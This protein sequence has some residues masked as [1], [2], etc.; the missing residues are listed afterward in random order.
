MRPTIILLIF[1]AVTLQP[2]ARIGAQIATDQSLFTEITKIRAIDNHAHPLQV[3]SPGQTDDEETYV[4]SLAPLDIPVRLRP[5]NPE[6]IF[7]WRALY[8]YEHTDMSE[9][10]VRELMQTK[11][12]LMHEQGDAYPLWVLDHLGI[13]VMLAN[14]VAMGRG[15]SAPRFRWVPFADPLM[16]PLSNERA[17]KANPDYRARYAGAERLLKHYLKDAGVAKLPLTLEGYLKIV[18]TATLERLKREGAIA[19]KFATAYHRTLDFDDVP[20]NQASRVYARYIR[21]GEPSAREY[22]A[23]QDFLFRY[24]AHEA[25]R[26]G[27][28]VQI[29]VGGGASGYFNQSGANPFVLEPVLNDSS[30]RTTQ[31]ILLHGGFPF[32]REA[33]AL[34]YK[35]SVYAEFSGLT[36]SLS[37]RELSEVLRSWLEYLPEKVLFG[38]DTFEISS[39]VSWADHGW[40]TVTSA[41]QALTLALTEMIND[42]EITRER[43]LELAK[44]VMRDNAIKLYK[45]RQVQ[46]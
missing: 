45:L 19:L 16:Y 11:Q 28:P 7:A 5:N 6:Y 33:R 13:E 24:I 34:I 25:G 17:S 32:A 21:G 8:G 27:L 30:L 3:V 43:A 18:V 4:S 44:M 26:L 14:R 37:V 15:L 9:Q 46:Q 22:K 31:F 23:L 36:F 39:E 40:L 41:R 42:R 10:H 2:R 35:P 29:H 12:R 20:Q 1:L 38:T